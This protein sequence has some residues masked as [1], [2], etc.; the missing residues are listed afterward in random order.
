MSEPLDKIRF[1]AH[2]S[3]LNELEENLSN[4]LKNLIA[5]ESKIYDVTSYIHDFIATF[6]E[7][8]QYKVLFELVMHHENSMSGNGLRL[9]IRYLSIFLKGGAYLYLS[10]NGS[11]LEERR[12]Y[13]FDSLI[14]KMALGN[15]GE[16]LEFLLKKQIY[17]KK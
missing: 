3:G 2:D 6:K 11:A 17:K 10:E 15:H 13:T 1:N 12:W 9:N 4:Y 14:N 16:L 7:N 8:Y 5:N